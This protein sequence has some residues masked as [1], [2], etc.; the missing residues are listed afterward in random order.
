MRS[1]SAARAR[2]TGVVVQPLSPADVSGVRDLL[3]A[4]LTER[5]GVYERSL[6]PDIERFPL[7]C[8]T[9]VVL[10][11]KSAGTVVGTGT[12]RPL[13]PGCAELVR[14]SVADTRRRTGIGRLILNQL[15][16]SA[17][18]RSVATVRVETTAG[19]SSAVRFYLRHGFVKTHE[20]GDDW[21]FAMR[22]GAARRCGG[23]CR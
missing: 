12:L 18:E 17:R 16:L 3:I 6:D 11:A 10:V 8:A 21:Y 15:L 13:D 9:C 20:R 2:A 4:G 5:W 19:W 23:V 14:M 22:L 1:E 7:G